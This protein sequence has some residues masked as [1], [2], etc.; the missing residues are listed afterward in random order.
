MDERLQELHRIAG[1]VVGEETTCGKKINYKSEVSAVRAAAA[2]MAKG[3][4]PLEAYPCVHCDGWHI[5]RRMSEAE[6]L[7]HEQTWKEWA[8]EYGN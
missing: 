4:K 6:L 8:N 7:E 2:M 1:R 5:G 3:S